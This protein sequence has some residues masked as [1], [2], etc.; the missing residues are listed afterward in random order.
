M[1]QRRQLVVGFER[2]VGYAREAADAVAA[3]EVFL[4]EPRN[5]EESTRLEGE[6]VCPCQEYS[7]LLWLRYAEEVRLALALG[8]VVP[9][10]GLDEVL[11]D[12]LEF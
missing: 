7:A 3:E 12:M 2:D 6:R 9:G 8:V 11:L 10:L 5:L 1:R 4:D